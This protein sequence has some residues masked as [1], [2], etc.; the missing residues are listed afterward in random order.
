MSRFLDHNEFTG[1]TTHMTTDQKL[2]LNIIESVMDVEP[3]I[4][5]NREAAE[6]HDKTQNWWFV[7]SIP[8]I[9]CEKWAQE[10]GHR[11][12]SKGWQEYSIKQLN[13]HNY[14]KLNPNNIKL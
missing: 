2:G 6:K 8:P 11:I 14:R 7:G 5:F 13:S 9:L 1:I 12:F 10:C 4:D 3:I